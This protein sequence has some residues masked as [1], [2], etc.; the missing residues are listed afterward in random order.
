MSSAATA[1]SDA[2]STGMFGVVVVA[3]AFPMAPE[4]KRKVGSRT[5]VG[6]SVETGLGELGLTELSMNILIAC[7][8]CCGDTHSVERV[9]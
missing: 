5:A 8:R 6:R 7:C 3:R 1:G 4:A 9:E 2:S